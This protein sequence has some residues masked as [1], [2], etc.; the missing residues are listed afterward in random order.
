MIVPLE[1]DVY[2]D[3]HLMMFIDDCFALFLTEARTPETEPPTK[4]RKTTKSSSNTST[5]LPN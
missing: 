4:S 1:M 3:G 5:E 2:V